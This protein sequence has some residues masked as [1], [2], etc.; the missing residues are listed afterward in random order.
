MGWHLNLSRLY[1][2]DLEKISFTLASAVSINT[3]H[4][5][6]TTYQINFLKHLYKGNYSENWTYIHN[7]LAGMVSAVH[8]FQGRQEFWNNNSNF[9]KE[10]NKMILHL[11]IFIEQRKKWPSRGHPRKHLISVSVNYCCSQCHRISCTFDI[12]VQK[13]QK[14][15][16]L[17]SP[18]LMF[19]YTRLNI[20]L[21]YKIIQIRLFGNINYCALFIIKRKAKCIKNDNHFNSRDIMHHAITKK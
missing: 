5:T 10:K 9:N 16:F 15:I 13:R 14:T 18:L 1:N 11:T 19:S 4:Q 3:V 6:A 8:T 20:H 12:S 21:Y 17:I 7:P 2:K